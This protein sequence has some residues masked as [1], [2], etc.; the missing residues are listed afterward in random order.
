MV[1]I[2]ARQLGRDR[3]TNVID[4]GNDVFEIEHL[5]VLYPNFS[6][7]IVNRYGNKVYE[8]KHNGDPFETP[9]W[10]DGISTGRRNLSNDP[11]PSGTYYYI[12]NLFYL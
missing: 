12:I 5:Q 6:M 8:Y 10:W 11:I 4:V 3:G 9:I 2:G 1:N 7:E